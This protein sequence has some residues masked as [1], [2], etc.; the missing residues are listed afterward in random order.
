MKPSF[1]RIGVWLGLFAGLVIAGGIV[2]FL[3]RSR[4]MVFGYHE[5]GDPKKEPYW[6]IFNP[7]RDKAPE[8]AGQALLVQIAQGQCPSVLAALQISDQT[9]TDTC[10]SEAKY[11]LRT[12]ELIGRK[13]SVEQ[14][15]LYYRASRGDASK[16]TSPVWLTLRK[17]P[18]GWM[19]ERYEAWY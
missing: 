6:S 14:V 16:L 15:R 18:M 11:P 1:R 7:F 2:L 5:S 17:T 19:L 13:D 8:L 4:P 9:K 10:G 3:T 12:W